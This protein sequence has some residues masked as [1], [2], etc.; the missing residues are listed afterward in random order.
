MQGCDQEAAMST[1]T[2]RAHGGCLCGGVRYEVQGELRPIVACHCSQCARTSGHFVA[3][4]A[5]APEYLRIV[6]DETLAWFASSDLADRGFCSRCGSSLFWK[7]RGEGHISIMAGSLVPPTRLRIAEHIYVA[8]KS[9]YYDITDG[10]P[11]RQE[12]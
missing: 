4:T 1:Q 7:P 3:A 12:W 8:S 10:L 9:D 6:T 11:Q 2:I 5:C